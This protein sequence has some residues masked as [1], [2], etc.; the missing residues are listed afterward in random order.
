M[1]HG[2]YI[3]AQLFNRNS[4]IS[5]RPV[6]QRYALKKRK[7]FPCPDAKRLTVG[8]PYGFTP[9]FYD[10]G[11]YKIL[12]PLIKPVVYNT[13]YADALIVESSFF[14]FDKKAQQLGIDTVNIQ[15][16]NKNKRV[17]ALYP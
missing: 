8:Q 13:V 10:I 9:I 7:H 16:E 11:G 15:R 5:V 4:E 2:Q 12:P 6:T 17:A 3:A 1:I 14:K